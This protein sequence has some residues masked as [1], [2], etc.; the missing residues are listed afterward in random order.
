MMAIPVLGVLVGAALLLLGRQLYWLFVAGVGFAVAMGLV[1]RLAEVD[2][3]TLRL[4]IALA[5]GFVGA[6]LAVWLQ[7]AAIG[8]AGFLAGG[9]AVLSLLDLARMQAPLLPWVLALAGA[10]IGVVL[11]LVLFDWGLIVL[12]SL[13]GAGAIVQALHLAQPATI[14]V[15]L[16]LVVAG[17]AIQGLLLAQE[18]RRA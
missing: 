13:A 7:K 5:A 15:F 12:S 9:Y 14:A 2:S 4:L 10:V 18:E 6:L 17:I 16:V 8:L 11:T 1:T 3:A